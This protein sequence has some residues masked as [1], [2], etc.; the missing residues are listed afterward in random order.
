MKINQPKISAIFCVLFVVVVALLRVASLCDVSINCIMKDQWRLMPMIDNYMEGTFKY[1][2]L[3]EP[4]NGHNLSGYKAMFLLNAIFCNLNMYFELILTV[5]IM[6]FNSLLIYYEM[7]KRNFFKAGYF[8]YICFFMMVLI[9]F[10]CSQSAYW[11][12]SLISLQQVSALLI[13]LALLIIMEKYR[14]NTNCHYL[15]L[16]ISILFLFI[17]AVGFTP[18]LTVFAPALLFYILLLLVLEPLQRRRSF[19]LLSVT[20]FFWSLSF[21]VSYGGLNQTGGVPF[22]VKINEIFSDI[23]GSIIYIVRSLGASIFHPAIFQK[24]DYTFQIW[25]GIGAVMLYLGAIIMYMYFKLWE[26]TSIPFIIALTSLVFVAIS[27]ITRYG[28]TTGF[29]FA[30]APRYISSTRLG[31]IGVFWIYGL[32]LPKLFI[33]KTQ[34]CLLVVMLLF[35]GTV[36]G[37][38]WYAESYQNKFL[39]VQLERQLIMLKDQEYDKLA[40]WFTTANSYEPVIE[41]DR[42]LRKYKLGPYKGS[43]D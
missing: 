33:R 8:M 12:Y 31:L 26:K 37:I 24:M 36:E 3:M 41:G 43:N 23:T 14:E 40:N 7:Q 21:L 16:A 29:D 2:D 17:L 30:A 38:N 6:L 5:L 20:I 19:E 27:V 10:S 1:S 28:G 39:K 11:Q 42:I 18:S 35:V 15:F 25:L 22:S 34:I 9:Y 13:F 4:L 32:A